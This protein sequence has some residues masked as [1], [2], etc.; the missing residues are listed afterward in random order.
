MKTG[1][2][3]TFAGLPDCPERQARF[4][5][6]PLPYEATVTYQTG[7]KFGPEGVLLASRYLELYDE[8]IDREPCE[9]GI[10]TLPEMLPEHAGPKQM[11]EEIEKAADAIVADGRVVVG[12]GGEHTVSVGVVKACVRRFAPLRVL[13][14][15]AHAD[16]RDAYKG[17]PY[18]HGCV[19]RRMLDAGCA[20]S[21][22]GIRSVSREEMEFL[23]NG[24]PALSVAWAYEMSAGWEERISSTLP[25]GAYY[26]T[27]DVDFFDPAAVPDT[28]TPEP[29]GFF[30]NETVRFL[31]NFIAREDVSIVGFDVVELAPR[32]LYSPS[33]FFVAKLVY[34][35]I[36]YAGGRR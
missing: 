27:I 16:L 13:H 4:C 36:G 18:S 12:I 29:G 21:S 30:W 17:T 23:R 11:V 24:R 10:R 22:V 20:V 32:N 14:L 7:T 34:K 25:G 31:R 8:E 9:A 19:V 26:I 28:G 15:D 6:L 1:Q 2:P 35:I 33:C 3:Y 5:I